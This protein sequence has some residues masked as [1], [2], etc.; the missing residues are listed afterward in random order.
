L[1]QRQFAKLRCLGRRC[2]EMPQCHGIKS[3]LEFDMAM[4]ASGN[5][6]RR[7]RIA[8]LL[9]RLGPQPALLGSRKERRDQVHRQRKMMVYFVRADNGAF[10]GN[11]TE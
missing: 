9:C 4:A 3:A 10:P 6:R 7:N 5:C 1:A 8:S 11:A 2:A